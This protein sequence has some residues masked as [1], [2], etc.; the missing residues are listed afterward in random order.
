MDKIPNANNLIII[1][2]GS[3]IDEVVV[4]LLREMRG[5]RYI[6]FEEV[7]LE[8]LDVLLNWSNLK[9]LTL[10]SSSL[11][12]TSSLENL[13]GLEEI[14]L[15]GSYLMPS[16]DFRFPPGLLALTLDRSVYLSGGLDQSILYFLGAELPAD[17]SRTLTIVGDI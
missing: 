9:T 1:G 3:Q 4:A 15:F 5:V 2:N 10:H 11:N 6:S 7:E 12:D 17:G 14:S 16:D 8:S 13:T